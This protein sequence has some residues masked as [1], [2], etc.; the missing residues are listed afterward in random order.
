M[1]DGSVISAI[2]VFKLS[3]SCNQDLEVCLKQE[4]RIYIKSD[5]ILVLDLLIV[6]MKSKTPRSVSYT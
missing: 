4:L 1:Y 6:S 2:L 3:H 5:K